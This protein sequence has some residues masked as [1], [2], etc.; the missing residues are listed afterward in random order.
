MKFKFKPRSRRAGNES[1]PLTDLSAESMD[2]FEIAPAPDEKSDPERRNSNPDEKRIPWVTWRSLVLG[3]FVSIGGI[4]FGY[5]TGQISGF[6]EMKNYKMRFGQHKGGG[7]FYF[8]NVRSGLLVAMVR[9][10]FLL[11]CFILT[12]EALHRHAYRRST[13]RPS[14]RSNR[15][16]IFHLLLVHHAARRADHPDLLP[17]GQMVPDDDGPLH[18]RIRSWRLITA[19]SNVPRRDSTTTHSWCNGMVSQTLSPIQEISVFLGTALIFI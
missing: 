12:G 6:L 13:S 3:A 15:A 14:R 17:N 4:I 18:N 1:P 11:L 10:K 16:Q 2:D 19:S 7:E 9:I 8:N 5:D